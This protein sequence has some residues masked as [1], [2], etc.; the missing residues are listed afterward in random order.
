[1]ARPAR[2]AAIVEAGGSGEKLRIDQEVA[3]LQIER[4]VL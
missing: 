4:K 2:G 3:Q 1:V